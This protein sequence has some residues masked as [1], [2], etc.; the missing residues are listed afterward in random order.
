MDFVKSISRLIPDLNIL[1]EESL[2]TLQIIILEMLV[3]S[4]TE[5]PRQDLA[6]SCA[7]SV[8][9]NLSQLAGVAGGVQR[10]DE[11]RV[12]RAVL[13]VG[14]SLTE[15]EGEVRLVVA[16]LLATAAPLTSVHQD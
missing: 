2:A 8:E 16:V 15:V 9:V 13:G 12:V 1:V 14:L 7:E 3:C 4:V 10:E 6:G 5:L 11:V